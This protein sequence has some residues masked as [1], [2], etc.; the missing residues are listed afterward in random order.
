MVR[1]NVLAIELLSRSFD[2][3]SRQQGQLP[4]L[5]HRA[6]WRALTPALAVIR[7]VVD[8]VPQHSAE[9]IELPF[10]QGLRR[11]PLRLLQ[12]KKEREL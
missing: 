11:P 4:K 9:L 8:G 6:R 5:I 1:W 7:D 12:L 10:D 3:R 2:I